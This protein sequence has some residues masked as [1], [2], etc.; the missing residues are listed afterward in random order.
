MSKVQGNPFTINP[1]LLKAAEPEPQAE[2]AKL[3]SFVIEHASTGFLKYRPLPPDPPPA[4]PDPPAQGGDAGPGLSPQDAGNA[5]QPDEAAA[6][7]AAQARIREIMGNYDPE[8]GDADEKAQ[9]IAS[10]PELCKYL[11]KEQRAE[12]VKGLFDGDTGEGEEDAAMQILRG[13]G[14]EDLKWVVGS[15]GWDE[16]EDELDGGDLTEI[17]ALMARPPETQTGEVFGDMGLTDAD[18]DPKSGL[19]WAEFEARVQAYLNGLSPDERKDLFR[20]FEDH[21]K[22]LLK[23][24][25]DAQRSGQPSKAHHLKRVLEMLADM[26]TDPAEK[27]RLRQLAF[28]VQY[29]RDISENLR[30]GDYAQLLNYLPVLADPNASP[31]ER[32]A[33]FETL[34]RQRDELR[35]MEAIVDEVGTPSQKAQ[36][37]RFMNTYDAF[38]DGFN[39]KL[40][41]QDFLQQVLQKLGE[42]PGDVKAEFQELKSAIDSMVKEL[43]ESLTIDHMLGS[44]LDDK[45]EDLVGSLL[46]KGLLDDAPTD[47]KVKLIQ[48]LNDGPTGDAQEQRILDILRETKQRDP[49]EFYQIIAAVGWEELDSNVDGEEWD[50]LMKLMNP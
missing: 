9:Q 13:A 11:T 46:S 32:T 25:A 8:D 27:S 44:D 36:M 20:Y 23:E 37:Q 21:K 28:E 17:N 41:P 33:V 24:I 7:D 6:R 5:G 30:T 15:V 1:F 22:D 34:R 16:L 10:D 18:F 29:T 14:P 48:A 4:P 45:A 3:L 50:T 2:P 19:E 47:V 39:P 49:A 38:M 35:A 12:L 43:R 40:P 31:E 42:I 26:T